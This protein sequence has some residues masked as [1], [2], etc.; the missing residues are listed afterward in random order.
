LIH[1]LNIFDRIELDRSFGARIGRQVFARER[2]RLKCN[3]LAAVAL[4]AK[5][6]NLSDRGIVLSTLDDDPA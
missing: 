5:R 2:D 4:L 1:T 6:R 3:T